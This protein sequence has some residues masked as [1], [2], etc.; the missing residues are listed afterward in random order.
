[1]LDGLHELGHLAVVLV[2]FGRNVVFAWPPYG[3]L[4]F[5]GRNK[6]D[7]HVITYKS[8]CT[9]HDIFLAKHA[10]RAK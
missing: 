5:Y 1:M 2:V 10:T 4:D 7:W 3:V 9:T 6:C 8:L